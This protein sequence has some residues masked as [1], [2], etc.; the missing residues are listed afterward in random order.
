MSDSFQRLLELLT[1]HYG[2]DDIVIDESQPSLR[3]NLH[4]DVIEMW[5]TEYNQTVNTPT[6]LLIACDNSTGPIERA[7]L[8]WIVGSAI[9]RTQVDSQEDC[10][11]LLQS[12]GLEP[13]LAKSLT[14]NCPGIASGAVWSVYY[15]RHGNLVASPILAA[16]LG[17]EVMKSLSST[18]E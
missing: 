2:Q 14:R 3:I 13:E 10:Q 17:S 18:T 12:L 1:T 15:E 8:T 16:A 9:R 6:N 11:I 4:P 7:K 5:N